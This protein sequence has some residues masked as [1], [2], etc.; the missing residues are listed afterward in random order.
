[1]RVYLTTFGAVLLVL[2]ASLGTLS[3]IAVAAC[4]KVSAR[5]CGTGPTYC[6]SAI[7]CPVADPVVLFVIAGVGLALIFFGV[8]T[9]SR[10]Q[11]TA[12]VLDSLAH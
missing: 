6:T 4:L 3:S 10:D 1:M 2:G 7:S 9:K 11:V 8:L 5:G 12:E